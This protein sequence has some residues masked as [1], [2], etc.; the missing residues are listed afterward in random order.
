MFCVAARALSFKRAAEQL[1][2]TP[3]AVSHR[4]RELEGDLDTSLFERQARSLEL[5]AAGRALFE[6]VAPL[7]DA[8]E[9]TMAR[10]TQ[11][12]PRRRLRVTVP[13]FFAS[14]L[15]MPK[16]TGFCARWPDIDIRLDSQNPRP[17]EHPADADAS[18]LLSARRPEGVRATALFDLTLAAVCSPGRRAGLGP[19]LLELPPDAVLL[20]H[21]SRPDAWQLWAEARAIELPISAAVIEIDTMF[22]LVRAAERDMGFALVPAALCGAWLRVGTLVRLCAEDLPMDETYWFATREADAE[23]PEVRA[24]RDWVLME[25][26][27]R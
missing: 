26:A 6:E 9:Q 3:S 7:L 20:V 21:R 8:L 18:I 16:L 13:Q 4:I 12:Q 25:F 5:S 10:I 11:R 19:T 24:L 15:F 1:H 14:E 27:A 22:A 23:R 2:L 17:S